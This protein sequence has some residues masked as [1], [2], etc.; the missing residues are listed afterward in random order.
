MCFSGEPQRD[1]QSLVYLVK[2]CGE[3]SATAELPAR[4]KKVDHIIDLSG[5][6][7]R[8]NDGSNSTFHLRGRYGGE[9]L[10]ERPVSDQ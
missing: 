9:A 3:T 10:D 8:T 1:E 2:T 5:Q 4:T 7:G 6:K